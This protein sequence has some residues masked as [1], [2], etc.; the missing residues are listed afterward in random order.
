MS[1][2]PVVFIAV[3]VSVSCGVY[4]SCMCLRCL[5]AVCVSVYFDVYSP[6]VS[7]CILVFIRRVCGC[8]RL[9]VLNFAMRVSQCLVVLIRHVYVSLSC[10]VYSLCVCHNV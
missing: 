4:S 3:C 6:C 8:R 9:M 5:F 10:G 1:Q 2:F 7:Q